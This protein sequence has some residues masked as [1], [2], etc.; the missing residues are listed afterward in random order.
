MSVWK[1][2]V[3]KYWIYQFQYHGRNYG[4]R[5]FP[6]RR[7]ATTGQE[8]RRLEVKSQ[9]TTTKIATA[10]K[11]IANVYLDYAKRKFVNDVYQRK[12]NVCRGFRATL[13]NGDMQIDKIMPLDVHN[14]LKTLESNSQYN[15]H[16]NELSALFS[17]TKKTY[18]AQLPFLINPCVAIEPMPH[19][20]AEKKI[21]TQKE[22]LKMI[23]VARPGDEQDIVLACIHTLGRIDEV[24]RL[25]WHEDV[26][27]ENKYIVLWTRKRKNGAYEPDALHMDQDL[28]D[29]LKRRWDNRI[30]DK[31][32]FF[33]I[34]TGTRYMARPKMMHSI[35]ERAGIDPIGTTK[36]KI[37]KGKDK[38]KYRTVNVHYGFHAL[39]HFMASY[40][41]DKKK[42]SLKT[43]SL[44]LRHK[45]ARTTE[46]YLH[47]PDVSLI[48]AMATIEGEFNLV[49]AT[50]V[51]T[52][53]IS[54]V[55]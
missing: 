5:G 38:D 31:W 44:L 37:E 43:T 20:T 52:Q 28:Y 3:Y 11:T 15:E 1:D 35:C 6:T 2:K 26:N 18:A 51:A 39:R 55:E 41:L 22:V 4:E 8:K 54:V 14:Y 23:A 17:W 13:P 24:L 47:S 42:V 9:T 40:L 21:P 10:F 36:R 30:Q 12:V 45:K 34:D 49:A 16:R 29:V 7:A 48:E 27:F 25:R 19:V 53:N 33:N 46:I 32:V 50:K